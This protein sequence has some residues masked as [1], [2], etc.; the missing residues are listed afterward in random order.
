[1]LVVTAAEGRVHFAQGGK[2]CGGFVVIGGVLG[3]GEIFG[4]DEEFAADCSRG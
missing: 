2:Q 3:G 4:L 1:M